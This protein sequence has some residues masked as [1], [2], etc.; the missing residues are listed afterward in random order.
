MRFL[1]GDAVCTFHV[2]FFMLSMLLFRVQ[3][4]VMEYSKIILYYGCCVQLL[5][6]FIFIVVNITQQM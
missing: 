5:A 2:V 6:D 3:Q 4:R 1:T